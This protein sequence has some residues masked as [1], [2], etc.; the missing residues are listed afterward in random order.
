MIECIVENKEDAIHAEKIGVNR[1]ELVSAISVGGLTPSYGTIKNVLRS[2]EIPVQVMVRPH[3]Y[4]FIYDTYDKEVM[5]EEIAMM[6]ELGHQRIVI[7]AL[8][9]NQK[10]DTDFFDRLFEKF[11]SLDVTFHR[12][13][14]E[15]NDQIEAYQ[16]LTFYNRNVKRILTSGRKSSCSEGVRNLYSLVQ[17]QQETNGPEIL[18]GSGLNVENLQEIHETVQAKEYHFGRGV[19]INQSME[20]GFNKK[21]IAEIK[22]IL[23]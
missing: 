4:G 15:V 11:P 12:A 6:A 10:I 21:A 16:T 23:A 7:G 19:R 1:L 22:R 2:V 14:D 20:K 5:E 13:F 8:L 3:P 17:L 9:E 18:P